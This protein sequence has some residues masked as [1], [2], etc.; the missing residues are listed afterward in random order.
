MT[1]YQFIL[2]HRDDETPLGDLARDIA[3]DRRFPRRIR[4]LRGL[5]AYLCRRG[6][7]TEALM[8]ADEALEAYRLCLRE[9][10]DPS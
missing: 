9:K 7:C 1:F 2:T 8:A 3:A 6:A 4:T 5:H 10:V